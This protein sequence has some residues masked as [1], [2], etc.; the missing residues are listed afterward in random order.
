M[1]KALRE[2]LEAL[3]FTMSETAGW[4]NGPANEEITISRH[5]TRSYKTYTDADGKTWTKYGEPKEKW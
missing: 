4:Y 1:K 2:R 3:G 5:T